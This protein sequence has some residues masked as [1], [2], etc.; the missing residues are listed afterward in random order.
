MMDIQVT[1]VPVPTVIG[2]AVNVGVEFTERLTVTPP[3]PAPEADA[4]NN[5]NPLVLEFV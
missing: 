4:I 3:P 5:T 1:E 2:P